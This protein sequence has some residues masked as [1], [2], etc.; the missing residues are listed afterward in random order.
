M[1]NLKVRYV[2]NFD[3]SLKMPP[4]AGHRTR[5]YL[6]ML[7]LQRQGIDANYN[8][9]EN[10]RA[11]YVVGTTKGNELEQVKNNPFV[12]DICNNEFI[13][14][15]RRDVALH[16]INKCNAVTV[17]SEPL[18]DICLNIMQQLN[19]LKPVYVIEDTPCFNFEEPTFQPSD[20]LNLLWYGDVNN[21]M[22]ADWNRYVFEPFVE[23]NLDVKITFLTNK[24]ELPFGVDKIKHN[25]V[26]NNPFDMMLQREM[27]L[28]NDAIILCI[29][30]KHPA[31]VTKTF[32]KLSDGIVLGKPIFASPQ[33]SYLEFKDFAL[34]N[35]DF[36]TSIKNA[37]ESKE[38]TIQS[39]QKGQEYIKKYYS[40]EKMADKWLNVFNKVK[41][42]NE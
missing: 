31:V 23:N 1:N 40:I 18:R 21:F 22:F 30:E 16:Y 14:E 15:R 26:V 32:N 5:M 3:Y 38:K 4:V 2:R 39:V 36:V 10:D 19:I 20:T 13:Y 6:P 37:L 12:Y 17:G 34:L 25:I 8:K 35:N 27:C 33:P 9:N 41:N 28:E 7:E 42:C 29:N 11:I 24:P